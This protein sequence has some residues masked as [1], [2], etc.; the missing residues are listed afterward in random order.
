MK[1]S[2]LK[3]EIEKTKAIINH[4]PDAL[5]Y[6]AIGY[7]NNLFKIVPPVIQNAGDSRQDY[8]DRF[9][10][11]LLKCDHPEGFEEQLKKYQNAIG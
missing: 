3:S 11:A 1:K 5:V 4:L 2:V 9:C 10:D 8:T 7:G 6:S